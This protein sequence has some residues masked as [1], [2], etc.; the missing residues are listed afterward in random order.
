MSCKHQ[1]VII[2]TRE[3]KGTSSNLASGRTTLQCGLEEGHAGPHRDADHD[4]EWED[5]G[6]DL[7]H[8]MRMTEDEA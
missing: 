5:R 8:I 3:V 2:F 1:A 4:E 7:T 6:A